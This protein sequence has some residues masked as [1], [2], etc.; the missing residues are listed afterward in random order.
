MFGCG[1]SGAGQNP[2]SGMTSSRSG[3][4][5]GVLR[6]AR[7]R[8]M[9]LYDRVR[10]NLRQAVIAAPSLLSE[11]EVAADD[12]LHDL[13]RAA[14]DRLHPAVGERPGDRVF[15]HV[16]VPPEQLNAPVHGA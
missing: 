9:T 15:T 14:E 6:P 8:S 3:S 5:T 11:P 12:L 1:I 10:L 2:P 4:A 13:G 16:P 7:Q